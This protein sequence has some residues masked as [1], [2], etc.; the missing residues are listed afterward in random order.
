MLSL[1][2]SKNESKGTIVGS[3]YSTKEYDKFKFS[4]LNRKSKYRKDLAESI[5]KHGL[6]YP[7]LVDESLN[8]LEGQH[9]FLVCKKHSKPILYMFCKKDV[10]E[11]SS[12]LSKQS[13]AWSLNDYLEKYVTKNNKSYTLIRQLVDE[14]KLSLNTLFVILKGSELSGT[15]R[16]LFQDGRIVVSSVDLQKYD[17]VKEAITDLLELNEGQFKKRFKKSRVMSALVSII[18]HPKYKHKFFV[19]RL[20]TIP[21]YQ[22]K[23]VNSSSDARKMLTEVYNKNLGKSSRIDI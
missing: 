9:R 11:M 23:S 22:I 18:N 7:I 1:L 13:K 20:R 4:K 16:K 10:S 19:E 15:N 12:E 6:Q 5:L 17:S 21:D 2:T 3:V 8:I 14:S